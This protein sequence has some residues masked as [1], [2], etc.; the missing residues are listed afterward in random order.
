ML[1]VF[2]HFAELCNTN[3]SSAL[4]KGLAFNSGPAFKLSSYS[5]LPQRSQGHTARGP[6]D[7]QPSRRD[8]RPWDSRP[9]KKSRA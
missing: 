6:A 4:P 2:R 8:Q 1:D 7:F 9:K 3:I 5:N